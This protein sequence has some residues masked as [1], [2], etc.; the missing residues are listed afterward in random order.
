MSDYSSRPNEAAFHLL[1]DALSSVTR[2]SRRNVIIFS[3]LCLL[4]ANTG[5][6]PSNISI[7]FFKFETLSEQFVV[8][9][10]LAFSLTSYFSFLINAWSD[11]LHFKYRIHKHDLQIAHDI[12]SAISGPPSDEKLY[13][14]NMFV[15]NTGYKPYS[16]PAKSTKI[17]KYLKTVL[18]FVF[19]LILGLISNLIYIYGVVF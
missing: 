7:P 4:A 13:H 12:D 5:I 8:W 2:A 17:L 11:F 10:L 15:E 18:D 6:S 1:G 19:P 16:I 9:G 3:T 14:Y